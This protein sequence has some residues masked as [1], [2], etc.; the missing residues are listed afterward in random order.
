MT[1]FRPARLATLAAVLTLGGA[2]A[3]AGAAI[4]SGTPGQEFLDGSSAGSSATGGGGL[5]GDMPGGVTARPF[6]SALSVTTGGVTTPVVVGGT[7]APATVRQGD[8]TAV[9]AP[10]NL[11]RADQAP[12]NGCYSAPNRVGIAVGYADNGQVTADLSAPPAG[13]A[14]TVDATTVIDMT[15]R[16]NTLGRTLRWSWLNGDLI[17]WRATGLGADD[18]QVRVRFR[19]V[20]TPA[21]DYS[22]LPPNGCTATPVR[23]CDIERSQG[24]FLAANLVLSLDDT[25]PA[26]LTGAVFATRGAMSGYLEPGGSAAAPTLDLQ[27]A[28]AHLT[29]TGAPQIG[30]ITA[31][32][33]SQALLEM[34]GVLPEDAATLFTARRTGSVG[35]QSA[36]R[37]RRAT[38]ATDGT[39]GL[40]VD[41]DGITFSAPTYRVSR[42]PVASPRTTVTRRAGRV[43]VSGTVAACRTRACIVT[44]RRIL[45]GLRGRTAPVATGT[46]V[47]AGR[48]ALGAPAAR[49]A[50]GSRF[51]LTVRAPGT[52]RKVLATTVARAR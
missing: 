50:A 23:D 34:Y 12:G 35:T 40:L 4:S 37:F 1:A 43:S 20:P 11:C 6:I 3:I 9:V 47:G 16:L 52:A 28:S 26:A 10:F 21:F 17:S 46:T 15:I 32:I 25:L 31:L 5:W 14:H 22:A 7:A 45:P 13:A 42:R 8:V 2:V 49:L 33:P 51:V 18:A 48:F 19:P 30:A 39:D 36:P 24:E 41:I 38:L 44:V 27:I 29:A